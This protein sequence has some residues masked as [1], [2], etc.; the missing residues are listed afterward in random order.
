M[1]FRNKLCLNGFKHG[2]KQTTAP[3]SST[4]PARHHRHHTNPS[5]P[6][7]SL[8]SPINQLPLMDNASTGFLLEEFVEALCKDDAQRCA[9][10][11]A[12]SPHFACAASARAFTDVDES[13]QT[14]LMLAVRH[15]SEQCT[16][17]LLEAGAN[18]EAATVK[19]V[20]ALMIGA[21]DGARA[22]LRSLLRAGAD[23]S[24]CLTNGTGVTATYLAAQQGHG[25]CL[26]LLVQAGAE[27]GGAAAAHD[28]T[29]PLFIAAQNGHAAC[30]RLLL[31]AGASVLDMR[32]D[33]VSPLY[34]SVEG[35]S[36][37]HFDCST[38][39]V[40][41]EERLVSKET[42][43]A[44]E[45]A[46]AG[47]AVGAT[48]GALLDHAIPGCGSTALHLAARLGDVDTARLLCEGSVLIRMLHTHAAYSYCILILY[49]T[50]A[51][52]S[53][54]MSGRAS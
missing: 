25:A 8:T 33:G 4:T 48:L 17:L 52:C 35:R 27:V 11:L 19:G 46:V 3:S 34:M 2:R 15:G 7:S 47:S 36:S 43:T 30:V 44:P 24:A 40:Q 12:D 29:T 53:R 39:I 28:G 18:T 13:G 10:W 1:G 45:E 54:C 20:T 14:A 6:P 16:M 5:P 26:E 32:R 37:R 49:T 22:C 51:V 31:M 21:Q 23:P 42:V 9:T 38:A 41:H 50:T